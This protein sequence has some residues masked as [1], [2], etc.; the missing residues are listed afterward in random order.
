LFARDDEVETAWALMTNF[1][2]GWAQQGTSKLP[3]YAAGTWGPAEAD[4]W[5]ERDGRHWRRL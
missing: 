2:K 4:R 3:Q 1:L 5:M